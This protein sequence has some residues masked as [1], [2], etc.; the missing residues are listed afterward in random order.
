MLDYQIAFDSP[1]YLALLALLP[2]LWFFSLRSLAGLGRWRKFAA[3]A[4][5]TLVLT[6]FVL[7]LAELQLVRTSDR[8]TV[9]YLVDQSQSISNQQSAAML[10]YVNAG[11]KT[12]D[13]VRE[14]RAGG[15]HFWA[16]R[17]HRKFHR[18]TTTSR[19]PASSRPSIGNTPT[20]RPP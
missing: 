16:G 2:F 17:G 10:D 6:L 15:D 7:A 3:I 4:L 11:I 12:R 13:K 18:S 19:F 9:M 14:D 8:V 1:W 5:R 20:W